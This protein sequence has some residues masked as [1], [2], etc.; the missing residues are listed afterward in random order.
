MLVPRSLLVRIDCRLSAPLVKEQRPPIDFKAGWKNEPAMKA[1]LRLRAPPLFEHIF[2]LRSADLPLPLH[3]NEC[4]IKGS[5]V[6]KL[7]LSK[8]YLLRL[9]SVTFDSCRAP[10][11]ILWMTLGG[12]L[13]SNPQL[14]VRL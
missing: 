8:C 4:Q 12:L 1:H 11:V 14:R 9:E 7:F 5:A 10:F 6:Y 13:L 3:R 2:H